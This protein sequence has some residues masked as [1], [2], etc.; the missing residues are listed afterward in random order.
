LPAIAGLQS[1][2]LTD[3]GRRLGSH[4]FNDIAA[5]ASLLA[6]LEVCVARSFVPAQLGI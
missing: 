5:V 6:T 1:I 4:Y 3:R 2:A